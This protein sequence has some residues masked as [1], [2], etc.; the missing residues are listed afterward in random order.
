MFVVRH[1]TSRSFPREESREA[2][3][4]LRRVVVLGE[5]GDIDLGHGD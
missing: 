5:V 1:N 2:G 4:L 3:A